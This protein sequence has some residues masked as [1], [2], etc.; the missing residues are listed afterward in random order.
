MI[1]RPTLPLALR[2]R[3]VQISAAMART[4][5]ARMLEEGVAAAAGEQLTRKR[6][7]QRGGAAAAAV[8]GASVWAGGARAA[9]KAAAPRIAVVGGGLAG[10]VSTYR[11][12]QAGYVAE[13]HEA[14]TR[15]GGR[16]WTIR[17][18]SPRTRSESTAAS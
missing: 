14:S 4:P 6:L 10:L 12:K 17:G 18:P 8:A 2:A 15:L 5:L 1:T 3:I 13:L 7:L 16:C 9:A 11:L